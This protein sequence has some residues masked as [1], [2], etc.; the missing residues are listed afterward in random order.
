M[1]LMVSSTVQQFQVMGIQE[2]IYQSKPYLHE[3][4]FLKLK[5]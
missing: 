5:Q 3:L 2:I 4:D 1:T